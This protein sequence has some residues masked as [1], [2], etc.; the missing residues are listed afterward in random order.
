MFCNFDR[1][2]V[3]GHGITFPR[4]IPGISQIHVET[5]SG[6][7]R[8]IHVSLLFAV[9]SKWESQYLHPSHGPIYLS[10]RA[11]G[12]D[13]CL[14]GPWHCGLWLAGWLCGLLAGGAPPHKDP[15][16]LLSFSL[17]LGLS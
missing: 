1:Q 17:K 11:W 10:K 12:S 15:R 13:A 7:P 4:K 5:F 9:K 3:G 14:L 8:W 16:S 6:P 2:G